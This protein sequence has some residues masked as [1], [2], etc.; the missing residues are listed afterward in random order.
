MAPAGP[1]GPVTDSRDR[2]RR[3][4]ER[5]GWAYRIVV[6]MFPQSRHA[7]YPSGGYQPPGPSN[8]HQH[9]PQ[10]FPRKGPLALHPDLRERLGCFSALLVRVTRPWT[11]PLRTVFHVKRPA[12][13]SDLTVTGGQPCQ[14][15]ILTHFRR[16]F[17]SARPSGSVLAP[18]ESAW[19]SE[20]RPLR[21]D[22][23]S[24]RIPGRAV[25]DLHETGEV[26]AIPVPQTA[27]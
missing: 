9:N 2:G 12:E 13:N 20:K 17:T 23:D 3:R 22:P 10:D 18:W 5:V 4:R 14:G 21:R 15:Q 11:C 25:R 7:R 19:H 6:D 8:R 1:A 16:A 26:V 24:P 27:K